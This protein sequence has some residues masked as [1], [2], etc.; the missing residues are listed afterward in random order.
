MISPHIK[1]EKQTLA[2]RLGFSLHLFAPA[3]LAKRTWNIMWKSWRLL[4]TANFSRVQ[5]RNSDFL[6]KT[7]IF[8]VV[9]GEN[10]EGQQ[11]GK[12]NGKKYR[13]IADDNR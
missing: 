8:L 6:N 3:T 13:L 1:A 9:G 4:Q 2:F 10:P 11:T 7:A 12:E 5:S